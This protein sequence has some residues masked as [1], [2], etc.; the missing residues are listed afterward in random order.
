MSSNAAEPHAPL[1]A[2]LEALRRHRYGF[3]TPTMATHRQLLARKRTQAE[4]LRDVFGWSLPF[5]LDLLAPDIL[6]PLRE[7]GM[8]TARTDGLWASEVR[9][10]SLDDL[11]FLHSAFPPDAQDAV[12]FGPDTYRFA[13]FLKSELAGAAAIPLLVDVGAGSGAGGIVAARAIGVERLVLIDINPRALR[14]AGVNAAA[15]GL[16]AELRHAS[17]LE[18]LEQRPQVIVANPPFIAGQTGQTYRQGGDMHGARLS[19]EWALA[20]APA[21]APGGIMLMY[22]GS[23]IV[24]GRDRLF[25]ALSVGL[26][27]SGCTLRYRELDPDIFGEELGKP[28]YVAAGVERIAAVGAVVTRP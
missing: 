20:G 8:L 6:D 15:A 25:E 14:L 18:G 26:S 9:V 17:G 13:A 10:S 7:A 11:L 27:E 19:L 23:A 4:T 3:V 22:T 24:D 2:L 16:A 12:F 28:A 21:L 1:L 5:R